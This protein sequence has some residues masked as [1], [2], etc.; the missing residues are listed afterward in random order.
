M[1]NLIFTV[2]ICSAKKGI[3]MLIN[4]ITP[5]NLSHNINDKKANNV[6][7]HGV[8]KPLECDTVSFSGKIPKN[9]NTFF[10]DALG[11]S[12]DTSE[13]KFISMARDYHIALKK[14]SERLKAYGF[15]YDEG[16]NSG[17][18]VKKKH[19]VIQKY[20]RQ[21]GAQDIIRGTVYWQDQQDISAFKKFIDE[22]KKEGYDIL[23]QRRVNPET[24]DFIRNERGTI[25]KFPD[26]EIRQNG[27]K[28]EDLSI[29]GEFLQR[30]EISR[31]RES[32][33]ADWQMRFVSAKE[34]GNKENKQALEL[35]FKYGPKYAEANDIE[36]KYVYEISRKF[37]L[38]HIDLN[39][40]H[41][42]K[43]SAGEKVTQNIKQINKR[44]VQFISQPLFTNAY[45]ADLK[46]KDAEKIPVE[47]S[48]GYSNLLS[49]YMDSIIRLMPK[50]YQEFSKGL[51]SEEQVVGAIKNSPEYQIRFNKEI[52]PR[53]IKEKRAELRDLVTSWKE[54]DMQ[55]LGS[56]KTDLKTTIEKF[57]EK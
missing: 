19:S 35:I 37:K 23:P 10:M 40:E 16:Y 26:L 18:T 29:L 34:S 12:Y 51:L 22:M 20:E 13:A 5:F 42:P 44:L 46:I 25:I 50:Y 57:G 53:E 48:K 38:L 49:G 33:Y 17:N 2:F 47:I 11:R 39:P 45:N 30:A 36:H 41:H 8:L 56:I 24:G 14:V 3:V 1:Q 21:G 6:Q 4:S 52:T 27:I 9:A 43:N 55:E 54:A 15:F 7:N 31:P 32:G 28:E